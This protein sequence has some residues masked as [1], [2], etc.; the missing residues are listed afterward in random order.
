[1]KARHC[2]S[3]ALTFRVRLDAVALAVEC[4][5]RAPS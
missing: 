3:W 1:M 4:H 2:G 5:H